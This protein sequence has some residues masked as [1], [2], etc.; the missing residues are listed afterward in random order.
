MQFWKNSVDVILKSIQ[1]I[2]AAEIKFNL[3]FPSKYAFLNK[4][5]HD[6][7]IGRMNFLLSE[8]TWDISLCLLSWAPK[9]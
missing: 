6:S 3:I 4:Q 1:I 5:K 2:V 9:V 8:N 7:F